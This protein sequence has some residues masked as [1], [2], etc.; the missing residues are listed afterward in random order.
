LI[1]HV[2]RVFDLTLL[3]PRQPGHAL[4]SLVY[5]IQR[6]QFIPQGAIS[7]VRIVFAFVDLPAGM[8]VFLQRLAS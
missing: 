3:S 7:V 8:F 2:T 1:R 4:L 5:A 6:R